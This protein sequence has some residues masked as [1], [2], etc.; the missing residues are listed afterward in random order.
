[1]AKDESQL[2]IA[3]FNSVD[4]AD[5]AAKSLKSWDKANDDIKLG[6]IGVMHQTDNG[7]IKTKKYGAHNTGSGAKIGLLLGVLAAI[8]PAVTLIGG[9]VAGVTGGGI[10]GTFSRKGLGLTDEEI[11][12][13]KEQLT[14][15]KAALALLAPPDEVDAISAELTTLGGTAETATAPT[16]EIQQ[17]AEQVNAAAPDEVE[18]AAAT[19]AS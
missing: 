7:K 15:G 11:G 14:T 8:L 13:I 10:L 12:R 5:A 6:A 19:T 18:A 16:E 9:V 17:V 2:V 4:E 1:M 3:Y